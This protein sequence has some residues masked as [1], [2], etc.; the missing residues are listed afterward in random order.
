MVIALV[1]LAAAQTGQAQ[2]QEGPSDLELAA[3]YCLG[4]ARFDAE[5]SISVVSSFDTDPECKSLSDPRY[6]A[7]CHEQNR[8]TQRTIG[9]IQQ[10]Y[11]R[12]SQRVLAYLTA[13]GFGIPSRRTAV[14]LLAFNRGREEAKLDQAAWAAHVAS[15]RRRCANNHARRSCLLNMPTALSNVRGVPTIMGSWLD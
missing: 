11:Q 3:A 2:E 10:Q 6:P 12:E 7:L 9:D 4:V 8:Q 14:D 15:P 5:H 1:G 13:K